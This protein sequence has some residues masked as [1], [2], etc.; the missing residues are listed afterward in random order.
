MYF[1]NSLLLHCHND[2]FIFFPSWWFGH[3]SDVPHCDPNINLFLCIFECSLQQCGP[4]HFVLDVQTSTKN[5]KADIVTNI[6]DHFWNFLS[7][8]TPPNLVLSWWVHAR[9]FLFRTFY[10]FVICHFLH[11]IRLIRNF[12][13]WFST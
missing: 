1:W 11:D 4:V 13:I 12:I 7:H 6:M 10:S 3:Y 5:Q 9:A 2:Y 8:L